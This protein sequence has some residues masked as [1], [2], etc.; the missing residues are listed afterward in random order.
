MQ[1]GCPVEQAHVAG[2][3]YPASFSFNC[4]SERKRE[5]GRADND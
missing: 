4:K 3:H 5:L 2:T 1:R